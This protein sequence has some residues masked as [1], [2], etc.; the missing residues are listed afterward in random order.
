M[1]RFIVES[2]LYS[3]T[4]FFISVLLINMLAPVLLQW[5]GLNIQSDLIR[6]PAALVFTFGGFSL[7]GILTGLLPGFRFGFVSPQ[8]AM[9]TKTGSQK[10]KTLYSKILL[11]V[12]FSA[13]IVLII[14]TIIITRQNRYSNTDWGIKTDNIV[15]IKI[16]Q[17][18]SGKKDVLKHELLQINGIS[19]VVLTQFNPGSRNSNWT[20]KLTA[21]SVDKWVSFQNFTGGA[22]LLDFF[23]I[24]LL[25]GQTFPEDMI[26]DDS[27]ALINEAAVRSFG[28]EN[29]IGAKLMGM[30]DNKIEIIGIIEDFHYKSKHEKIAPLVI[31]NHKWASWCYVK[32]NTT[33]FAH[34]QDILNAMENTVKQIAPAFPVEWEFM[35]D[36]IQQLYQRE[37]QFQKQV[38]SFSLMAIFLACL[39]ILGLSIFSA[40]QR[41]KEIGVRKVLGASVPDVVC[42]V[43]TEFLTWVGIASFIAIPIAWYSMNRWLQNFAYRIDMSWWMFIL[44]GGIALT[45]ALLT[46]SWQAI[47]AATANPVE[48]LRYE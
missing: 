42:L 18:L 23:D 1:G 47:R 15:G 39:G 48:S 19:D 7:I 44:A 2:W 24:K 29:P 31:R 34:M 43:T 12:Q 11:A 21:P 40:E 37:V 10:G 38:S 17:G 45:I 30:H 26:L 27:K 20:T 3:A 46:V 5:L 4:S 6:Q 25:Q 35:D 22:D 14:A 36:S 9:K 13:A 33:R 32:I 8:Q 41:T 16:S 28:I